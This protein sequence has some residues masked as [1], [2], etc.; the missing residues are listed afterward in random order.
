MCAIISQVIKGQKVLPCVAVIS[1]NF[2][3]AKQKE[4]RR[5]AR[6]KQQKWKGEGACKERKFKVNILQ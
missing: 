4:C 1:M 5:Q 6:R 3:L 2:L